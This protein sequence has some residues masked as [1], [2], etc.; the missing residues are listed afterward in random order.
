[1]LKYDPPFVK[2]FQQ[3]T[4]S[5]AKRNVDS[6]DFIENMIPFLHTFENDISVLKLCCSQ[7][8]FKSGTA[9]IQ[10]QFE[11]QYAHDKQTKS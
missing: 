7:L 6:D 4:L 9:K 10:A 1:M 2:Y 5:I 8:C 11:L 3:K